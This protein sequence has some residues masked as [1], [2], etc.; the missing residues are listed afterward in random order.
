MNIYDIWFSKISMYCEEKL[1][2]IK[3]YNN[4]QEIYKNVTKGDLVLPRN[5]T[6]EALYSFDKVELNKE[7][8]YL[9][10]KDV[11]IVKYGDDN[12]P[13]SLKD[14]K[15]APAILYYTG[16]ITVLNNRTCVSVV[17]ARK[18]TPYGEKVAKHIAR[19]L[20]ANGICVV[21]GLARGIDSCAQRAA[22]LSK[23]KTCSVFGCGVDVIYPPENIDLYKDV[24]NNGVIISEYP[25]RTKP[26]PFH[27][28]ERNRLISALAA[29]V[30]VVEAGEK[31]G[32][33]N[34]ASWAAD[35]NVPLFAVPGDIT[36]ATSKGTNE[37]IQ[38]GA[39]IFLKMSD[40][41]SLLHMEEIKSYNY[42]NDIPEKYKKL[43]NVLS[44]TPVH[45]NEIINRSNIDIMCLYELLFEMQT[46]NIVN[47]I[48]G[49]F[50]VRVE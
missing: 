3:D 23:G 36:S 29:A 11:Q 24:K 34:T 1:K 9:I 13:I 45:I 28:L 6:D 8:E 25:C 20:A 16:D 30:V 2:L 19:D 49:S 35:Q 47:C 38:E 14:Y 10:S 33:M 15:Y 18:S 37:L 41:Y 5:K 48:D 4:S 50:Y 43:Y 42:S 7:C 44:D 31:S 32:A 27:F 26:L 40:I 39:N 21:S 12:Y 46:M 17:G 22:I